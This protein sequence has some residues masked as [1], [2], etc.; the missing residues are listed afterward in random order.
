MSQLNTG[1]CQ[2]QARLHQ[3]HVRREEGEKYI[4]LVLLSNCVPFLISDVPGDWWM[5]R[6]QCG[7]GGGLRPEVHLETLATQLLDLI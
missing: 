7:P 6:P 3:L 1:R 2:H 5:A 4:G